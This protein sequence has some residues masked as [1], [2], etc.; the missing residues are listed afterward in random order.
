MPETDA[1]KRHV[2][3]H[4]KL[5]QVQSATAMQAARLNALD[6]LDTAEILFDLKRYA[7]SVAFSILSIEE[8]GKLV[9]LQSIFL[10]FG[11]KRAH[12]WKAYRNHRAKTE[13]L[14]IGVESRIR[15]EFPNLSRDKAKEIGKRGPTPDQLEISKQRAIYSDCL[16]TADGFQCH[17]PR[18]ADWRNTAWDRL[19]EARAIVTNLRD[20]SPE[21]LGIWLKHAKEAQAKGGNAATMLEALH[22]ELLAKGF[23]KDG[24]WNT[25]LADSEQEQRPG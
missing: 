22:K 9:Y 23:V 3:Y 16:E 24:W 17:L 25:L 5:T 12:L 8:A 4:G 11:G 1:A 20:Y 18:N 19:C 7:H 13:V 15:A 21:E 2:Q 14:N 10:G 6:L